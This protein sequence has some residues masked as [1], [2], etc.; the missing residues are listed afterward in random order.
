MFK[1]SHRERRDFSEDTKVFIFLRYTKKFIK[2]SK[3]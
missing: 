3:K 2:Q 1:F